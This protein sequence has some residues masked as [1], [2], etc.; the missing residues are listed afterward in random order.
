MTDLK[1]CPFCGSTDIDK[2]GWYDGLGRQGPECMACGA[3][4]RDADTWNRR[5]PPE[6]MALVPREITAESGHKAGMIGDFSETV[7]MRCEACDGDGLGRDEEYG[8][9]SE[10]NG[11]GE[12]AHK[13]PVSW[14]T[15]KAIH[16]RIV[17]IAEGGE[18]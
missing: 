1:F 4:A 3:T 14:T 8:G 13:V 10:C 6:G 11:A 12:Y 16:R 18:P 2:H 5:K 9:C 17:E 15:I 7:L